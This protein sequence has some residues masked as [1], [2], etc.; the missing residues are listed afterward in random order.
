MMLAN[1]DLSTE[2][3][4]CYSTGNPKYRP[5]NRDYIRKLPEMFQQSPLLDRFHGIIPGW[6]IP[7]FQTDQQ[8]SGLGLKA[9]YFAEVCHALRGLSS[10]S[11]MVRSQLRLS[12]GKRDCTAIERM[13]T[14]LAKLLLINPD[15]PRFEELVVRPAQELRRLVRTQLN[16]VDPHG[17][18]AAL[19]IKRATREGAQSSSGHISHYDL[20]EEIGRGGTA[21]VYRGL[22][23]DTGGIVAVKIVSKKSQPLSLAAVDREIAVYQR[24]RAIPHPHILAVKDI[25]HDDERYALVTEYADGGSLWDLVKGEPDG[26]SVPL[27]EATA[28]QIAAQVLSGIVEM[29]K[30]G[31][32]H[33]DI[34]PQNILRCDDAWKIADFGISKFLDTPVT[35]YTFQGAH[36][37]PWAPPE[38]IE[39]AAA[40]PSADIYAW[41]RVVTYLL[42]A[43]QKRE[44]IQSVPNEWRKLLENCVS[45]VASG[46]PTAGEL[47]SQLDCIATPE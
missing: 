44:A 6:E 26:S 34:K 13:A 36:T 39:G 29:H 31:I 24:L 35:G 43:S 25:F 37:A 28:K 21:Y 46:R 11:Q 17:Y 16:A 32:V 12:G 45:P 15:H 9:D 27:G 4:E 42:T 22:D 2:A 30:N 20:L 47:V 38:Q 18:P 8:A 19:Q 14:G 1:I 10:I 7:P 23:K 3:S 33:R 5:R 41:G 40:H